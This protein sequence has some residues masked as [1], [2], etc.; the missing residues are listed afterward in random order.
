ME[1]ALPAAADLLPKARPFRVV[2]YACTSASSVIGSEKV[3]EL[4]KQS[5][6]V[7][8]VTNTLRAAVAQAHEMGVSRFALLPPYVEQVNTALRAVFADQGILIDVFGTF[9]ISEESKVVRISTQSIVDAAV[10][11]GSDSAVEAAF[12]SCTN[13]R[14]L[15]AIPQIHEQTG[16]PALS[17]NQALAWHMLRLNTAQNP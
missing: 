17:G 10:R 9:G 11:Q 4:V 3:E 14:T 16:N 12:L 6:G 2:G 5:C 1:H 8:T 7:Q 15:D 13:L